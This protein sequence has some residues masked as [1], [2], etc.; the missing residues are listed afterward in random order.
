MITGPVDHELHII[1]LAIAMSSSLYHLIVATTKSLLYQLGHKSALALSRTEVLQ[2]A[3][4]PKQFVLRSA[5]KNY[6][7]S[8]TILDTVWP[9]PWYANISFYHLPYY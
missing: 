3:Y 2:I 6:L 1:I 9:D 8:N 7:Q 5:Y 4:E